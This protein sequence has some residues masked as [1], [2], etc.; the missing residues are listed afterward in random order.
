MEEKN[1]LFPV[2]KNPVSNAK[3]EFSHAFNGHKISKEKISKEKKT[4]VEK[5]ELNSANVLGV[6]NYILYQ[7]VSL[8][9]FKIGKHLILNCNINVLR[10]SV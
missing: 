1:I 7:N 5:D 8:K 2:K 6:S 9:S 3:M 4:V 10:A